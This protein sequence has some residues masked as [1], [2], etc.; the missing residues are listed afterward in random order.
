MAVSV[1]CS[2][3]EKKIGGV[4]PNKFR[5]L[6]GKEIC[7][8]CEERLNN[9]LSELEQ[10]AK[11]SIASIDAKHK[12]LKTKLSK[13]DSACDSSKTQIN[14]MLRVARNEITAKIEGLVS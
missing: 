6:T 10:F 5:E 7:K 3:C 13:L 4:A 14:D 2:I 12:A 9:T 8:E 1:E 11:D